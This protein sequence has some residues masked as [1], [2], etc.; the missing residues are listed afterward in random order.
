MNQNLT[1]VQK[2]SGRMK[3]ICSVI[4]GVIPLCLILIWVNFE[5]TASTF[6]LFADIP[7]QPEYMTQVTL[8][9]G[10]IVSA[11]LASFIFYALHK[12]RQFFVSCSAGDVFTSENG[13]YL[14][15][16]SIFTMLYAVLTIPA[17]ALLALILTINNPPGE[18]ILSISLSSTELSLVFLGAVFL[19]ISWIIK[20]S[21]RIAE[22]N[23]NIV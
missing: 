6:Q 3:N 9:F 19:V 17:K 16:F 4:M 10:F 20:E 21:A 12:L 15:R 18:R 2:L 5:F 23:A 8:I 11:A 22:D 1:H 13:C 7:Y 14:H